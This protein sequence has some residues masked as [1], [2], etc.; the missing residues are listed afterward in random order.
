MG[1]RETG[2]N[3]GSG[4]VFLKFKFNSLD[5]VTIHFLRISPDSTPEAGTEQR[6][7]IADPSFG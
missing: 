7:R 1:C 6:I 4:A 5:M 2:P 3:E